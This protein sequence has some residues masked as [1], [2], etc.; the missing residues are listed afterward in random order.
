MMQQFATLPGYWVGDKYLYNAGYSAAL[1]DRAFT[2]YIKDLTNL[3]EITDPTVEGQE[4]F[5]NHHAI[6][7]IWKVVAFQRV[8][9][10]Y[11]DIPYFAAGKGFSERDFFPTYDPQSEIYADMLSELEEA[12]GLL[13]AS[14]STPG[15]QDLIYGGNVDQWQRY[16]LS[17]I[18]I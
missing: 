15:N 10:L 1:W 13:S 17:L 4:E 11:G 8:T 18:H 5:A 7:K 9:D 12:V 6:A 2:N 3:V 16:G 14:A